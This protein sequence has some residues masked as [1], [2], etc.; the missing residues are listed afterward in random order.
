MGLSR[1]MIPKK[2]LRWIIDLTA[3]QPMAEMAHRVHCSR[4]VMQMLSY[5]SNKATPIPLSSAQC[6]SI[7]TAAAA[8]A[9][10]LYNGCTLLK[11]LN[12]RPSI[13]Q[14]YNHVRRDPASRA[15]WLMG[16]LAAA[17]P[18][19]GRQSR[20]PVRVHYAIKN[21]GHDVVCIYTPRESLENVS[22]C[23]PTWRR[24]R[25]CCCC[26]YYR[27]RMTYSPQLTR[28]E[29]CA[30]ARRTQIYLRSRLKVNYVTGVPTFAHCLLAEW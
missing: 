25:A 9:G 11:E 8:A 16:L 6:S 7:H 21:F 4:H 14:Q 29:E 12:G 22:S 24:E 26:S 27:L 23:F 28:H 17:S 13:L 30:L 10:L 15:G 1:W 5:K 2:V 19:D 20:Q 18:P 3:I